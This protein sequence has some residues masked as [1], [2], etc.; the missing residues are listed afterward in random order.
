MP[1]APVSCNC[2]YCPA[3]C[4]RSYPSPRTKGKYPVPRLTYR[5]ARQI[6]RAIPAARFQT[7]RQATGDVIEAAQ[8]PEPRM[9]DTGI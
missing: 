1:S 2:G 6:E 8:G 7:Y 9:V 4:A 3:I 5:A